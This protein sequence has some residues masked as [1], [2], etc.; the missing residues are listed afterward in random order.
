MILLECREAMRACTMRC[1][2]HNL[3]IFFVFTVSWILPGYGIFLSFL[4]VYSRDLAV[5]L[6]SFVL[7]TIGNLIFS[8]ISI[9]WADLIS[10][11]SPSRI[12]CATTL[13]NQ[14]PPFLGLYSAKFGNWRQVAPTIH[15]HLCFWARPCT[16]ETLHSA[17]FHIFIS[18]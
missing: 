5:V 11:D 16:S 13:W 2:L 18:S 12:H 6:H 14:L 7:W 17:G 3:G 15:N 10:T 8:V 1:Y 9:T 4:S